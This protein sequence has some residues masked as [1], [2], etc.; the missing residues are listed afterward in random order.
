M[1]TSI[2]SAAYLCALVMSVSVLPA[3]GVSAANSNGQNTSQ[4]QSAGSDKQS[5]NIKFGKVT[6]VSG[7]RITVALGEMT[8]PAPQTD[9]G[10]VPPGMPSGNGFMPD[11]NG[12]PPEMPAGEGFKP[13]G[14]FTPPGMPSGN[15]IKPDGN[16][17]PPEMPA[18]GGFGK[19]PF[20]EFTAS[21]KK[22]KITVTKSI[23][24]KKNGKTASVSDISK[25]DIV[26]L[27][28]NDSN[29]LTG[30][31]ILDMDAEKPAE[32]S[33]KSS[34]GKTS[35]KDTKKTSA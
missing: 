35:V 27:I 20:G 32:S 19:M 6:A 5:Q 31:E 25:N 1:K 17:A 12:A 16:G 8:S 21:G 26:M 15:D 14:E 18:D 2:R 23:T 29:K 10:A 30:I 7:K 13:N 11:G 24:I 4:A 3:A 9:N 28:Y 34:T 33:S 22:T